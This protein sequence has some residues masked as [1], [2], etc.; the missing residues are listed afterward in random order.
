MLTLWNPASSL[1]GNIDY[2][3]MVREKTIGFVYPHKDCKYFL[4]V[5]ALS[6]EI[7]EVESV[8]QFLATLAIK[9]LDSLCSITIHD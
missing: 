9:L 5:F 2:F 7:S 4:V 1:I 3:L 6:A 8:R